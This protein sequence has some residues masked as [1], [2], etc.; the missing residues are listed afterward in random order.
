MHFNVKH[1]S[2]DDSE[3]EI[4]KKINYNFDQVVSFAVGPDGKIGTIGPTGYDGPGGKKGTS[5]ASGERAVNWF[6]QS[7]TPNGNYLD[8]WIDESSANLEINELG[9]TGNWNYTGYDLISSTYLKIYSGISGPG[10]ITDKFVVALNNGIGLTA[11][12]SLHIGDTTPGTSDSNP[13]R[14]KL[15]IS[16]NDQIS[17]P[18]FTFSKAENAIQTSPS[19]LWKNA[20]NDSKLLFKSSDSLGFISVLS[21]SISSG[22]SRFRLYGK[23]LNFSS[24][25]NFNVFGNSDFYINS[26]ITTNPTYL[27]LLTSNVVLTS[28]YSRFSDP[29]RIQSGQ[30]GSFGLDNT[31]NVTGTSTSYGIDIL[32]TNSSKYSLRFFDFSGY[33]ILSSATQGSSASPDRYLQTYFGSTG[34]N[35][36]GSTGAPYFYHVKKHKEYR[37]QNSGPLSATRY[38]STSVETLNYVM[39]IRDLQYWVTNNIMVTPIGTAI[40]PSSGGIPIDGIYLRIPSP[41]SPTE[42]LYY[43]DS[44]INYKIFLN[45]VSSPY[46]STPYNDIKIKG[47]VWA[48]TPYNALGQQGTPITYYI[49]FPAVYNAGYIDENSPIKGCSYIELMWSAITSNVNNNPKIF[50]KACS[51]AAG[52]LNITNYWSV[53]ALSSVSNNEPGVV[54]INPGLL[55]SSSSSSGGITPGGAGSLGGGGGGGSSSGGGGGS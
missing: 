32:Q 48:Y 20:G 1:I 21:M 2:K 14:S 36:A 10:G 54:V 37:L 25:N 23:T 18:I 53:G 17:T 30:T 15:I 26:N 33:S 7:S 16:T 9:S 29:T 3:K 6:R 41:T 35:T 51:G 34:S 47:L 24:N 22:S 8:K 39:D 27:S 45:D 4:V 49:N 11:T 13:N 5:G 12:T 40:P 50:W 31:K 44:S 38:G 19:F 42:P 28:S 55:G 43:S 46:Y 52:F